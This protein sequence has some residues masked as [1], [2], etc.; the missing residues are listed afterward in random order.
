[1]T[2]KQDLGVRDD[3]LEEIIAVNPGTSLNANTQKRTHIK[4]AAKMKGLDLRNP[5]RALCIQVAHPLP[6]R[7]TRQGEDR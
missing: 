2:V 4:E 7:W 1:M 6:N 3:R 5:C